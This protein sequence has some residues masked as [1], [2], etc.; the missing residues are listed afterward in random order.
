[1]PT[2]EQSRQAWVLIHA[3][4]ATQ[5]L[6]VLDPDAGGHVCRFCGGEAGDDGT[7]IHTLDCLN[8]AAQYV[9]ARVETGRG[10]I[11]VLYVGMFA[12]LI[13]RLAAHDDGDLTLSLAEIEAII[14]CPLSVHAYVTSGYWMNHR[15]PLVRWMKDHGWKA[16]LRI[17]PREVRFR[18]VAPTA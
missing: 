15:T 10:D 5:R 9:M 7:P 4:A 18:R 12:P 16:T 3:L 6:T 1:M 13:A 11:G 14:G 8:L 17:K 2:R